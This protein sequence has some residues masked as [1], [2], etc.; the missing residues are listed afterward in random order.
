MPTLPRPGKQS[1][2]DMVEQNKATA[3]QAQADNE[4]ISSTQQHDQYTTSQKQL[5]P[6]VSSI[7]TQSTI[8]TGNPTHQSTS[9]SSSSR[10]GFLRRSKSSTTDQQN[11]L[12]SAN[13]EG[14][15][16][17]E[18]KK[19]RFENPFKPHEQTDE[20]RAIME[21]L[22][23]RLGSKEEA[24]RQGGAQPAGYRGVGGGY[25]AGGPWTGGM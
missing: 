17:K 6:E 25:A 9:S 11:L 8:D 24:I 12:N 22:A 20:D 21:K 19:S 15:K 1:L 23:K 2:F 18:K 16:E 5:D 13:N 4:A 14:V 7:F 3:A 10:F